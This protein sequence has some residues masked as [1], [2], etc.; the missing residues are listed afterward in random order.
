MLGLLVSV[1][2]IIRD[3]DI[4]KYNSIHWGIQGTLYF[5]LALVLMFIRDLAYMYRIRVLTDKAITWKH[6]FQVIMLWEFSSALTPSVVGGSAAAL[7]FVT[8]ELNSVG[9]ATAIVMVTALLDELFYLI[10]VPI[11]FK[12]ISTEDL[13][14]QG[15]FIAL[16]G[17]ELP[18][19]G[20]FWIGYFFIF[21]L[22]T[23]I[24]LAIF[25]R[26]ILFKRLLIRVFSLRFLKKWRRN[27]AETGDEIII[28]SQEMKGKPKK[29]W[30]KAFGATFLSWTARFW[31]VNMLILAF[32][33][34]GNQLLIYGRQLVM[35]VILLISPTPGGSGV[36]E[37][38]LPKFIGEFMMGFGD[39]IAFVWRIISYYAYLIIGAIILPIWL[40]RIYKKHH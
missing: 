24:S 26:P 13:F 3:F 35:W 37:Y 25:Y 40:R 8:K 18:T 10:M 7:F 27:A 1:Y 20:I 36:A 23:I 15:Y 2:M 31:V 33:G 5:I 9:K 11:I 32:T 6:S 12:F 14:V 21:L 28:T 22:T 29:Y 19:Q 38:F 16:G 4:E 34:A 17:N 39:E 30:I